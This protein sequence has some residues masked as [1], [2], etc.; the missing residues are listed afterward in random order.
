MLDRLRN[1]I[2]LKL[3]SVA[4][5]IAAWSYLRLT[6]N[7]VIAAHFVQQ[8]DVP[9]APIGL[10]PDEVAQFKDKE[11]VVAVDVGRGGSIKSDMVRAVLSLDGKGPGVYNVPVQVIAPKLEIRSLSP[12]SVTLEIQRV[13]R[14]TLPVIV[15]Y[16][17]DLR[18]IVVT[19]K[20]VIEP[21]LAT[22]SGP[23]SSLA[24]ISD[25]RVDIPLPTSARTFDEMVRPT[26]AD[27]GGAEVTGI[28]VEPNLVH[29]LVRFRPPAKATPTKSPGNAGK[30]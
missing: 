8:V 27:S 6:P 2:G 23:M 7:P 28:A 25:V 10:G 30:P 22:I 13:E 11:A 3:L 5:A 26:V 20:P 4:I 19:G 17:G 18:R 9:I 12:A 1:N 14:R 21:T 24:N 16:V 15:H 29:V